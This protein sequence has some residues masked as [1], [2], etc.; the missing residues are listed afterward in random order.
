MRNRK[1]VN[2]M[3]DLDSNVLIITLNINGLNIP[4]KDRDWQVD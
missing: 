3:E 1:Q 2:K 4:I